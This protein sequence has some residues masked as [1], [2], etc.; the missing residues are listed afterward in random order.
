MRILQLCTRV[1]FPPNDGGTIAMYNIALSLKN[2]GC[3][4][5][6]LAFNTKKHFVSDDKI[7]VDFKSQFGLEWVY[8]DAS[9]KPIPAFLN[10]FKNDSYNISRFISADFNETLI[11]LLNKTLFNIVQM[12]GLFMAPYVETVRKHS[13]AKIVMRAHNIEH[14]IWQ[15]LYAS[16]KSFV[17][18]WYLRV[19][20]K[21][22]YDYEKNVLNNFDALLP[23]TPDDENGFKKL[24]CSIPTKIIPIGVNTSSYLP[25][26]TG[27]DQ[28]TLFHL[29]SMDWMPN[30]E[31][32]EWFLENVLAGLI[33]KIPNIKLF[34]AGKAMPV[35][36]FKMKSDNLFVLGKVSDAKSFMA[37]HPIMIVPLLSGSGMRVK[38]LE[39]LAAGNVIISTT[40]GAEG[41]NYT[42][43][44]N[45]FIADTPKEF[46]DCI[47]KLY[48]DKQLLLSVSENAKQLAHNEYD[49]NVIGNR[50][51]AFYNQL[52]Q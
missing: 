16:E 37:I 6:I 5:N 21:R 50:L 14:V 23:L 38:I 8:L 26:E 42:D 48:N 33:A 44:K 11:Q 46:T 18:K 28:P 9:V 7:D 34:L 25:I 30:I 4:V 17:K 49:N 36:I 10:L 51:T 41:I 12:E 15:R 29:G 52:L 45:L 24:G 40:I 43:G 2:T 39:G 3:E 19:L 31:G 35:K 13:S 22:L 32:V 1:P 27:F 20:A 47:Y